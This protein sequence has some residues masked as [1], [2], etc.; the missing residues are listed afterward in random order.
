MK[1][2]V[3]I[4]GAVLWCILFAVCFWGGPAIIDSI[5]RSQRKNWG[6]EIGD[7]QEEKR[8]LRFYVVC[9]FVCIPV[10]LIIALFLE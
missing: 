5:H 3:V 10:L 7:S 9:F 8:T 6:Q 1:T 4:S 2:L